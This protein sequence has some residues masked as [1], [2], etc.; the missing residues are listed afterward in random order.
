VP[1]GK[2]ANVPL[3]LVTMVNVEPG[4]GAKVTFRSSVAAA[5]VL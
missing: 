3:A 1:S 2:P 4:G 5:E